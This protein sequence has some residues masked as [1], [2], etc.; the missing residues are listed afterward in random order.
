[1]ALDADE[2]VV[3]GGGHVY[4]APLGTTIPTDATTA[5]AVGW[6]EL[7]YMTEDG[8]TITPGQES[9]ELNAW[10][11]FYPVRRLSTRKTLEA[12]FTMMQWNRET[13]ALAFGGGTFTTATGVT[14]YEPPEAGADYTVMLGIEAI[15]GSKITRII[16]E[17]GNVSDVG[18]MPFIRTGAAVIPITFA[19]LAAEGATNPF[20]IVSNDPALAA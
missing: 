2:I 12:S 13:L 10:Q 7:G 20:T 9:T 6:D 8:V 3:A 15:D 1:M 18:A 19:M 11:S 14:T 16:I 17:R 5:W 4:V